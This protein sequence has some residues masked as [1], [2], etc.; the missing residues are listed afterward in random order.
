MR[1]HAVLPP[2]EIQNCIIR[3]LRNFRKYVSYKDL[4]VLMTDF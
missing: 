2:T 1:I 4:K 3:R